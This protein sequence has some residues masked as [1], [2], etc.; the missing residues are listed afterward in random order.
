MQMNTVLI[1]QIKISEPEQCFTAE[2]IAN[3]FFPQLSTGK[4]INGKSCQIK[5]G[6]IKNKYE[7][8]WRIYWGNNCIGV[9]D[10][11]YK[12]GWINNPYPFFTVARYTLAYNVGNRSDATESGKVRYYRKYPKQSVWM[13]IRSDY[14]ITG[15]TTGEII[16]NSPR[17]DRPRPK[18]MIRDVEC[19]EFSKDEMVFC[20]ILDYE[21]EDY[22]IQKLNDRGVFSND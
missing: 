19:F 22:I 13:A 9:L 8:D 12:P 21:I 5:R 18:G 17:Y 14:K 11:E 1:P 16:I 6:N 2:S 15:I 10:T 4:I 3:A 7:I 20:D